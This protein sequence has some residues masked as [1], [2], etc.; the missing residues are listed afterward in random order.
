MAKKEP[1][2]PKAKLVCKKCGGT[3]AYNTIAGPACWVCDEAMEE[4]PIVEE[5]ND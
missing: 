4:G 2:I 3:D 1:K 5:K